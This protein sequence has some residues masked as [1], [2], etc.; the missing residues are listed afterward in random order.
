MRIRLMTISKSFVTTL[1]LT[2]ATAGILHAQDNASTIDD[3]LHEIRQ[4]LVDR[5]SPAEADLLKRTEQIEN[6]IKKQDH[7]V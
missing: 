2:F 5:L 7:D 3:E 4:Q 1:I 6:E